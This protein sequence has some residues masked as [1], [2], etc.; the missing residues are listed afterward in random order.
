MLVFFA[1][2]LV[3]LAVGLFLLV[4]RKSQNMGLNISLL[5]VA[6]VPVLWIVAFNSFYYVHY[7]I[8]YRVLGAS[9]L[10]ALSIL[11]YGIDWKTIKER[12]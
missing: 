8:A 7:W 3:L 9:V 10:A 6:C 4:V 11:V 12:R 5:L 1:V 2:V